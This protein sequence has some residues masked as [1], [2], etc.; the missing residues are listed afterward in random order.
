M[1]YIVTA[2]E[3]KQYD[4]AVSTHFGVPPA[5]LM[6]HAATAIMEEAIKRLPERTANI[7]IVA[8]CGNNG[9]DGLAAARLLFLKG[10]TPECVLVGEK[11]KAGKLTLLQMEILQK[12]GVETRCNLP[13]KE[14]DMIIDALFGIGLSREMKGEYAKAAAYINQQRK[15][16]YVLSVDMPSGI[17]TN[18]GRVMGTAV[19]AHATI[20]F[21]FKKRGLLLYPGAE[22]AGEILCRDIGITKESFLGCPPACFTYGKE[23]MH[24]LPKRPPAGNKGT[25]GKVLLIAGSEN[26]GGA[27]L[28]AG[29][30][31]YRTG[32]GLVRIMTV[33][34][35]RT[36]LLEK[37]PEAV[38]S[39]YETG[40]FP[41]KE[42][43]EN[44]AWADCIAIG[45]GLSKS[46]TAEKIVAAV[47]ADEKP[48]IIDADAINLIA[49]RPSFKERLKERGQVVLTPHIREFARLSGMK[50]E[51]IKA[52]IIQAAAAFAKEYGVTLVCKDVRTAVCGDGGKIYLNST[53][54]DGMATAG[55]GDVLTGIVTGLAAQGMRLYDAAVLGVYLHGLAGDLAAA[56]YGAY[57]MLAGTLTKQLQYILRD[58][59]DETRNGTLCPHLR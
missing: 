10:Y 15:N 47:L 7:L 45:P 55:A 37:L 28:L 33:K 18:T 44:I 14:Y 38:L 54:N 30:A 12:Y 46:K 41:R 32:A 23:D 29:E 39:I 36:L 3:M 58:K 2:N 34:E 21:A 56:K 40:R 8:G 4:L 49:Q 43:E 16:A 26:M 1:E 52:D 27:C 51:K 59:E 20:T 5:L 6:E 48:A 31:I 57:Y 35:N 11:E 24:R 50:T 19:K 25:F 53:G 9:G 17:E 42:L 22:Y 13:D